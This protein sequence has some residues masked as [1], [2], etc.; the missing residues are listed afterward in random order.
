VRKTALLKEQLE[1][2]KLFSSSMTAAPLVYMRQLSDSDDEDGEAECAPAEETSRHNILTRRR[3]LATPLSSTLFNVKALS[4][5][6]EL[7]QTIDSTRKERNLRLPP[8]VLLPAAPQDHPL[9]DGNQAPAPHRTLLASHQN[10]KALFPVIK[11]LLETNIAPKF[12]ERVWSCLL[13]SESYPLGEDFAQTVDPTSLFQRSIFTPAEDDLL[14]RGMIMTT[15]DS[16][17]GPANAQT[18]GTDWEEVQRR[19]LPSKDKRLL[20][21]R[22]I[23]LISCEENSKFQRCVSLLLSL[24]LPLPL[25]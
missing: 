24:P 7:L 4:N 9:A 6:S 20:Q 2:I 15:Y 10:R 21:Y 23:Q 17:S 13:P 19:Y 12:C 11:D 1:S 14:L 8:E 3:T 25:E 5:V 16:P 18:E 22:Q